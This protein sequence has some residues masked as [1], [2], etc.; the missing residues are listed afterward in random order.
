[1][2]LLIKF[3][4]NNELLSKMRRFMVNH[5]TL[6]SMPYLL[7]IGI[8]IWC[9]IQLYF[10]INIQIELSVAFLAIQTL[11]GSLNDKRGPYMCISIL[12]TLAIF[13][14]LII[15]AHW[16]IPT[17]H[18]LISIV[19]ISK[20]KRLLW[21]SIKNYMNGQIAFNFIAIGICYPYAEKIL[22]AVFIWLLIVYLYAEWTRKS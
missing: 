20:G 22:P 3:D 10:E 7:S 5:Y 14:Q 16:S 19:W 12:L 9:C 4:I 18:L 21:I 15:I 17:V 8:I 1:M 11:I 6:K 2:L 13:V